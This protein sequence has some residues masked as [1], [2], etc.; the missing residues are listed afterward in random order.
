MCTHGIERS[1]RSPAVKLL[2][3]KFLPVY[4]LTLMRHA[5]NGSRENPVP[6]AAFHDVPPSSRFSE[7]NDGAGV[8]YAF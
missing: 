8:K 5:A 1:S 3:Q 7:K 4:E 6:G 2:G